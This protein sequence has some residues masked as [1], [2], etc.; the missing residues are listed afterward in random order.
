MNF[1]IVDVMLVQLPGMLCGLRACAA[2]RRV[3]RPYYCSVPRHVQW[4]SCCCCSWTCQWTSCLCSFLDMFSG[5]QARADPCCLQFSGLRAGTALWPV[6]WTL[7][8]CSSSAFLWSSCL[9]SPADSLG[10]PAACNSALLSWT[11]VFAEVALAFLT[12]YYRNFAV[13]S[14]CSGA[15]LCCRSWGGLQYTPRHFSGE[16][17]CLQ[18]LSSHLLLEFRSFRLMFRHRARR[19]LGLACSIHLGTSLV[20]FGV[21]SSYARICYLNFAAFGSRSG[22]GLGEVLG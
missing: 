9:C 11:S 6:Q 14:F 12:G 22:T 2:L 15:V 21:C 7:R 3:C 16:L 4:T 1:K 17:W 13:F 20:N 5:P 10:W 18:R 8:S 19:S